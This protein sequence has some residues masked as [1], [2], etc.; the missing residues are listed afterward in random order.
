MKRNQ[1]A[2]KAFETARTECPGD[3]LILREQGRFYFTIGKMDKAAPLLREAYMR[4]PRDAMTLFFIARVDAARKNYKQA[5]LTMRRVAEM[6]PRDREILYHLGRMLGES[7][8]YFEAHVQL[9]YASLYGRNPKQ[10]MFHLKK[11]EGL[12]KTTKQKRSYAS[13]KRL[14]VHNLLVKKLKNDFS[15]LSMTS[16]R[17]DSDNI[18]FLQLLEA[19][20]INYS[21][22]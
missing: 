8:N 10:A 2:E 6:V 19:C 15:Q 16:K 7:G 9:A 22:T 13:C 20:E 12:A 18:L 4:D 5:I 11:A 21:S 1:E 3:T 14:S 17:T